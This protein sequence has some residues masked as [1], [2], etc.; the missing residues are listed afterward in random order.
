MIVYIILFLL[1]SF[2]YSLFEK[3]KD[4]KGYISFLNHHLKTKKSGLF[5]W[6]LLVSINLIT[7]LL[8]IIG[9]LNTLSELEIINPILIFKVC[10]INILI[11]LIGQRIAGDFQGAANLGIYMILTIIG[12]YISIH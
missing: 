11:L 2:G 7:S 5:F 6:W 1:I 4:K 9:L 10:A 8:L 12:W 3:L